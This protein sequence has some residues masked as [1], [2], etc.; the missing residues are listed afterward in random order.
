[1]LPPVAGRHLSRENRAMGKAHSAPMDSYELQLAVTEHGVKRFRERAERFLEQGGFLSDA[2]V[3][4][5]VDALV[6]AA[7]AEGKAYTIRDE[8]EPARIVDIGDRRWGALFALVKR[9]TNRRYPQD[10]A[11]VT[12]ITEW[13]VVQSDVEGRYTGDVPKIERFAHHYESAKTTARESAIPTASAST[14]VTSIAPAEPR[15]IS[16]VRDGA[17]HH[18]EAGRGN[19]GRRTEALIQAGVASKDIRVWKPAALRIHVE[20]D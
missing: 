11:V 3:A 17:T 8:G 16:F 6:S 5:Q 7:V 13:M 12:L 4:C 2:A 19:V 1:M 10:E 18:E 14:P 20:V 15:L 9:N